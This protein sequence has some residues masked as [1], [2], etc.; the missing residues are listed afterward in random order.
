MIQIEGASYRLRQYVDIVP[1]Q[2]RSV[3]F[4]AAQT[5]AGEKI[6]DKHNH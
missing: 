6:D 1:E 5:G 2:L 3:V 4:S